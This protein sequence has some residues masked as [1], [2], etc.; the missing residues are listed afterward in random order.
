MAVLMGGP[1]SEYEISI[2]T[3]QNII[4]ALDPQK[5][6]AQPVVVTKER[7]WLMPPLKRFPPEDGYKYYRRDRAYSTR[8][9]KSS[10]PGF[11]L[12]PRDEDEDQALS[13]LD[14]G[15]VDVV[16]IAMHG[17]F[18]EDGTVQGLLDSI[19]IP[20]TGSGV[21]ASALGMDK[22]RTAAVFRQAGLRVP[23]FFVVTRSRWKANWDGIVAKAEE[24]FGLPLMI[25]PAN[26]GSS[27]GASISAR[28]AEV[29]MG[30]DA[31]FLHADSVIVQR[32]ARG[33]EVSCGVVEREGKLIALPP[34]EIIPVGSRFF[35]YHAKYTP[36][37]SEEI[38]P[39]RLPADAIE[40]IQR[41][42]LSAHAAIGCCG[43]SRTDMI[44]DDGNLFVLEINTIPGL[45]EASIL[46]KQAQALGIP[47][48][49][50]LDLIIAAAFH[51]KDLERQ[52][53]IT[54]FDSTAKKPTL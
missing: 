35:D 52:G 45:S 9:D 28:R 44:L 1:S 42:A 26:R 36:G 10:T 51:R 38:T 48:P 31:A 2:A 47:F 25:K 12:A 40:R 7:K 34:T 27:V 22:P 16:F 3:G 19:G 32:Y 29:D 46:P 30:I 54:P 8:I 41:A 33:T 6:L 53:G 39:A 17:Q 24:T 11:A 43:M 18:G 13:E 50:L 14:A 4:K 49:R 20:Y 15:G 5:Y 37:A 23:D 21:L